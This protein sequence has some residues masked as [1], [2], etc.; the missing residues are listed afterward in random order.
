MDRAHAGPA[1]ATLLHTASRDDAIGTFLAL[2]PAAA[3][4]R[5]HHQLKPHALVLSTQLTGSLLPRGRSLAMNQPRD[6]HNSITLVHS[7]LLTLWR[8]W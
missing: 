2:L 4:W 6:N 1:R 8:R 5:R 7:A 3:A